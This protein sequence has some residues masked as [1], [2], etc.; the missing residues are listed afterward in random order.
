MP[1]SLAIT[2]NRAI[3]V[4][5]KPFLYLFY[6]LMIFSLLTSTARCKSI[7]RGFVFATFPFRPY[8]NPKIY[9]EIFV[10]ILQ[11]EGISL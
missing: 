9:K 4:D 10:C 7:R 11:L 2:V 8:M 5:I 1:Y 3:C 6:Y